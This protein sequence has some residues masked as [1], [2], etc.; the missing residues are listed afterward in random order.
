MKRAPPGGCDHCGEQLGRNGKCPAL[1]EPLPL[2]QPKYTGP[3]V[4]GSTHIG[5]LAAPVS[6]S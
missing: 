5:R 6:E 2:P 1:C 4:V 3:L